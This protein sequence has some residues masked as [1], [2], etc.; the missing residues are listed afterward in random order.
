[1]NSISTKIDLVSLHFFFGVCDHSL[2]LELIVVLCGN[3]DFVS[4]SAD[5][6]VELLALAQQLFG[7]E[8]E[9]LKTQQRTDPL[10]D[11]EDLLA[12]DVDAPVNVVPSPLQTLDLAV[13]IGRYLRLRIATHRPQRRFPRVHFSM[14]LM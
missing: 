10:Q 12:G 13:V 11:D 3:V 5:G 14:S 1:M 9:Q 2:V 6:V 8:H 7:L 4:E